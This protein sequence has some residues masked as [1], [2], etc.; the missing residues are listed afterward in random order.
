MMVLSQQAKQNKKH[1][2]FCEIYNMFQLQ[3]AL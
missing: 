1:L 3:K 2:H